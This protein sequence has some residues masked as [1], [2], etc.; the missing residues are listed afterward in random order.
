VKERDGF[1]EQVSTLRDTVSGLSRQLAEEGDS[2]KEHSDRR[3]ALE[4]ELD[5]LRDSYAQQERAW[6]NEKILISQV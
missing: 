2:N 6:K 4:Q 3:R 5:A 1:K